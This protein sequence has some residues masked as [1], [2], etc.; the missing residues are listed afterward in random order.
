MSASLAL[1][2]IANKRGRGVDGGKVFEVQAQEWKVVVHNLGSL[3]RAIETCAN[4]LERLR[5]I[6]RVE[7][8]STVVDVSESLL[9]TSSGVHRIRPAICDTLAFLMRAYPESVSERVLREGLVG[10]APDTG[11]ESVYSRIYIARQTLST[12]DADIVVKKSSAGY[13]IV[14][15]GRQAQNA[16][17]H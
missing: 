12:R 4:Y 14:V 16:D 5:G 8:S 17:S 13:R 2:L 9:L 6:I 3:P 10:F 1:I 7:N 11:T 15:V